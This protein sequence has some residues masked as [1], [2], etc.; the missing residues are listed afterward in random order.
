MSPIGVRLRNTS[1]RSCPS[2]SRG[3]LPE[4]DARDLLVD[5]EEPAVVLEARSDEGPDDVHEAA[6]G[7]VVDD[8]QRAAIGVPLEPGPLQG[9]AR[10]PTRLLVLGNAVLRLPDG[11]QDPGLLAR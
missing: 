10:V 5:V 7:L 4:V 2:A 11:L 1:S 6:L 9:D 8:Q 3:R